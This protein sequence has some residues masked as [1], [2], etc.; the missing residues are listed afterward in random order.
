MQDELA[1][2]GLVCFRSATEQPPPSNA[3]ELLNGFLTQNSDV[4]RHIDDNVLE[5]L[6]RHLDTTLFGHPA[7]AAKPKLTS[8]SCADSSSWVDRSGNGCRWYAIHDSGCTQHANTGQRENCPATCGTCPPPPSASR[9]ALQSSGSFC[10]NTCSLSYDGD[11]DDGGPGAE[12]MSCNWSTDCV[13]CGPRPCVDSSSWTDS[14][15]DGCSWYAT[16]DPGCVVYTNTGQK[17]NCPAACNE[18][19]SALPP[20]PPLAPFDLADFNRMLELAYTSFVSSQTY[21]GGPGCGMNGMKSMSSGLVTVR[22]RGFEPLLEPKPVT[23]DLAP[24]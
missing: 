10:T 13:D 23:Q 22:E 15:G 6:Q 9:R 4:A 2:E 14:Y 21:I 16:I 5:L 1:E 3:R 24:A 19:L 17:G 11:C 12:F 8:S 20:P 7:Q 18:C